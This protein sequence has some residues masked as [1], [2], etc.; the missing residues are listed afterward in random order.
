VKALSAIATKLDKLDAVFKLDVATPPDAETQAAV[1]WQIRSSIKAAPGG[2]LPPISDGISNLTTVVDYLLVLLAQKPR[3]DAA[4]T[5]LSVVIG[6]NTTTIGPRAIPLEIEFTQSTWVFSYLTPTLGYALVDSHDGWFALPYAGVQL[7]FYPN[8]VDKP[9]FRNG[10]RDDLKRAF[11]VEFGLSTTTSSTFGRDG[12]YR[13]VFGLP[14][15]TLA[16]ALHL[17]PYTSL[18]LGC[19][20]LDRRDS[21]LAIENPQFAASFFVGL[22]VQVNIPDLIRKNSTSTTVQSNPK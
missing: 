5:K 3:W 21:V 9:L 15:P 12:R 14:A 17:L 2:V 4:R 7:H 11:A 20:F 13:G 10:V 18:S 6:D 8:P 16:L 19:A 22:N 1:I